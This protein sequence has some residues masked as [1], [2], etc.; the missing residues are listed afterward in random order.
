MYQKI[1]PEPKKVVCRNG[2]FEFGNELTLKISKDFAR[3]ESLP[4]M[5]ELFT[6]FTCGVCKL[7]IEKT[8]DEG[9]FLWTLGSHSEIEIGDE[10]TY[11][12]SVEESGVA[13][14]GKDDLSLIHGFYT[15]LQMIDI[16]NLDEGNEKFSI[17]CG[18]IDDAPDLKYRFAYININI[19]DSFDVLRKQIRFIAMMKFSHI[20]F[21]YPG[22]LKYDYMPEL[23]WENAFTK[24]QIK[25]IINEARSLGLEVMPQFNSLGHASMGTLMNCKHIFLDRNPKLALMFE[26]MGSSFCLS[27]EETLKLLDAVQEEVIE[28]SGPGSFF[29]MGLDEAL[30]FATCKKCA[31]KDKA[32]FLAKYVNDTAAKMRKKGRRTMVWGDMLFARKQFDPELDYRKPGKEFHVANATDE[33]Y[34]HKALEKIDRD[35]IICDWQYYITQ[36]TL[37]T[38]KYAASLGFDV[39]PASWNN[40]KNMQFLA[41]EAGKHNYMGYM[42]AAWEA[43]GPNADLLLYSADVAWNAKTAKDIDSFRLEER[44]YA[45]GNLSRKLYPIAATEETAGW[46]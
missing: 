41:S 42:S 6:N 18:R 25:P 36:G 19:G 24:E 33:M 9:S 30:D 4:M 21:E 20:A 5:A 13:I 12:V 27:N 3:E 29:H 23:S 35:V 28:L 16:D 46:Q 45:V 17:G 40:F 44:F 39:I 14:K 38:S 15:M 34:T 10:Y 43:Q 26:P 11:A 37:E 8:H 22:S 7:N 31:D 1:Y 32:E 2:F